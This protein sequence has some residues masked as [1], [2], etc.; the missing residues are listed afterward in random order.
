MMQAAEYWLR[1]DAALGLVAQLLEALASCRRAID[2]GDPVWFQNPAHLPVVER[3][4]SGVLASGFA[5][6]RRL[7]RQVPG[8]IAS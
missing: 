7:A 4:Q 6:L 1:N 8:T 3:L 5:V 2:V